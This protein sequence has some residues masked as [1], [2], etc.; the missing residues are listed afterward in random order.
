MATKT[1]ISEAEYL[2]TAYDDPAPEYILGELVERGMPN[3]AHSRA[4][5]ELHFQFRLHQDKLRL[6]PRPELRVRV[7]PDHY[8]VAD[9]LVYSGSEP[10]DP[11]PEEIP[12][13]A[14]EVV[15]PDDRYE[16]IMTKL[17][18]YEA[19]GVKHVWL[20][21]PGLRRLSVYSNGSLNAVSAFELP[22]HGLRID[23][24]GIFGPHKA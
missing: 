12:L 6:Y 10:Q 19:W 5:G 3:N 13:V 7:A 22:G 15:S 14:A 2:S 20:V 18:D 9:L 8:R 16:E 1:L 17:A 21:D 4:C 23:G 24:G 11:V